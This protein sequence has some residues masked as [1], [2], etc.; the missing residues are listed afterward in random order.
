MKLYMIRRRT[1]WKSP[2]ELEQAGKRSK[3]VAETDYPEDIRWIRGYVI[4]DGGTLGTVC[5][6][7]A[8][9]EDAVRAHA[10]Q[11]RMPADEVPPIADTVIIRPD[12]ER[13]ASGPG[14]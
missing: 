13:V 2:D 10:D 8:S 9:S 4:E 12:P 6:Y 5:I 11:V 14:R 3:E 1:A 7:E